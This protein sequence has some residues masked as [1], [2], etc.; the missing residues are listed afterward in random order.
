MEYKQTTAPGCLV[1]QQDFGFAND[2]AC[3]GHSLHN[4]KQ[5][6]TLSNKLFKNRSIKRAALAK[7]EHKLRKG[8]RNN[9]RKQKI[10]RGSSSAFASYGGQPIKS[11]DTKTARQQN[12]IFKRYNNNQNKTTNLFLSAR[13]HAACDGR[14]VAVGQLG[15]EVVRVGC[16]K[17]TVS[18]RQTAMVTKQKQNHRVPN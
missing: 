2:G 1:Q 5:Q 3:D 17:T 18:S 11:P 7:A 14:V 16:K 10:T 8:I 12:T 6:Q 13:E 9:T 15:D 4:T